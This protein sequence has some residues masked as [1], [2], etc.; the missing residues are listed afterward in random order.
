[1]RQIQIGYLSTPC[2][3]LARKGAYS[4]DIMLWQSDG[5]GKSIDEVA[6]SLCVDK[7]TTL[8]SFHMTGSWKKKMYPKDKAFRK[9]T[10]PCH[11]SGNREVRELQDELKSMLEVEVSLSAKC[12]FLHQSGLIRQKNDN[13]CLSAR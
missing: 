2:R 6:Q 13:H 3:T 4:E 1:M 8:S 11:E 9:L 7:A 5:I 10:V 12:K